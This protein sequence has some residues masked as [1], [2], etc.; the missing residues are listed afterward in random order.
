M[1]GFH[2]QHRL[3]K[4]MLGTVCKYSTTQRLILI[5]FVDLYI[6]IYFIYIYIYK[7]DIIYINTHFFSTFQKL[8]PKQP[9]HHRQCSKSSS[10]SDLNI[11]HTHAL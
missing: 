2:G 1:K 8:S 10:D 4:G 11:V 9:K 3:Q 5:G 7:Y 6:Y